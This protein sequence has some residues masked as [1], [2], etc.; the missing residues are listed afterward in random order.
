MTDTPEYPPPTGKGKDAVVADMIDVMLM[1][2][3]FGLPDS[4]RDDLRAYAL[5]ARAAYN[6]EPVTIPESDLKKMIPAFDQGARRA[7]GLYAHGMRRA[8][9]SVNIRIHTPEDGR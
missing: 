7:A 1:A 4:M 3:A 8:L 9:E 2:A 5:A 6:N